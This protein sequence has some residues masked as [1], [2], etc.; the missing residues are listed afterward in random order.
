MTKQRTRLNPPTQAQRD[1]CRLVLD[2]QR[3]ERTRLAGE[4]HDYI[5]PDLAL[6]K[7]RLEIAA[8]E[9]PLARQQEQLL[10]F[11]DEVQRILTDLRDVSH[12][13]MPA[14]LQDCSLTDC[15]EHYVR[16][17]AALPGQPEINFIHTLTADLPT[18]VQQAVCQLIKELIFNSIKH[19]DA[20]LIDVELTSR[21][22]LLQIVVADDGCGYDPGKL[23]HHA[24]GIGLRNIR[25]T[26]QT[27]RGELAIRPRPPR[28]TVHRI[29]L[30]AF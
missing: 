10:H 28:G 29:W 27:L 21:N 14:S 20:T 2:W 6:L 9:A 4:L 18:W 22:G 11:G 17:V 12:A 1:Q 8:D 19:A 16:Q 25:A 5:G 26:V 23:H 13:L 7:L 24:N 3:Q 30:P 15:I